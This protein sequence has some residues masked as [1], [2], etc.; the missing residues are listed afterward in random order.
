MLP[1]IQTDSREL[2]QLQ[3][4]WA[5]QINPVLTQAILGGNYLK[6]VSLTTGD[7]VINHKLGRNL[8]GWIITRIRSAATLYDTQ[9]TNQS[10]SL[11]LNLN[12]SANCVVDLLVY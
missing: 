8:Q 9:D 3:T 2:S 7:N 12:S 4:T 11:T 1:Y 10:P 5:S 6:N